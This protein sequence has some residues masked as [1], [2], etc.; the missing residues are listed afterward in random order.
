MHKDVKQCFP[1]F[2][3]IVGVVITNKFIMVSYFPQ[4]GNLNE[5]LPC[6]VMWLGRRV[7]AWVIYLSF[8]VGLDLV[9]LLFPALLTLLAAILNLSVTTTPILPFDTR[10]VIIQSTLVIVDTF[11]TSFC[12]RNSESP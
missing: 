6:A 1:S 7:S 2:P 8:L 4:A 9:L 12:V 5:M 10:Y 3:S 11:G